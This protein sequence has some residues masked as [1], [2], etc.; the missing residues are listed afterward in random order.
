ME[1]PLARI[2]HEKRSK[3]VLGICR[4]MQVMN[5]ALGGSI[6]QDIEADYGRPALAHRQKQNSSWPSHEAAIARGTRLACII[7]RDAIRVNSIHHQAVKEAAEGL[8]VNAVAPDGIIEGFESL[9][10]PFY[11][12]VQ[13]H[14]ERL[15]QKDETAAAI[16]R[17]FADAVSS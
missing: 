10:H 2:L 4:G 1:I 5:V 6:Y 16:F 12:G 11:L 7:G 9:T 8:R 17:A 14:P 13:W 15:W 3:P